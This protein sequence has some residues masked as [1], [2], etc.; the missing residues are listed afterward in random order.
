MQLYK[1]LSVRSFSIKYLNIFRENKQIFSIARLF[2][3]IYFFM[4]RIMF[5]T[6]TETVC[7]VCHLFNS[8]YIR[9]NVLRHIILYT[10]Q[11]YFPGVFPMISANSALVFS[12]LPRNSDQSFL[13]LANNGTFSFAEIILPDFV[14]SKDCPAA[15]NSSIMRIL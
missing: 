14:D 9:A 4:E 15:A 10:S 3:F 13:F 1:Y 12:S 5:D 11:S 7:K 2:D 8:V 6:M